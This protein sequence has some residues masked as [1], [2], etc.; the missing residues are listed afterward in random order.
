[1]LVTGQPKTISTD[2]AYKWAHC[3]DDVHNGACLLLAKI[4]G[5]AIYTEAIEMH[6][7]YWSVGYNGSTGITYTPKGLAWLDTWGALRYSTTTAF[8]RSCIC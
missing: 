2:I 5:K 4:T 1:M 6:L 7:D 3:W 8:L